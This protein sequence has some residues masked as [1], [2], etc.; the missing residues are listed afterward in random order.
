MPIMRDVAREAGTSISTVSNV[1]NR[2]RRVSPDTELRVRLAMKK[3]GYRPNAY[4][5][6]LRRKRSR[7]LGLVIPDITNPFFAELV[8][9]AERYAREHGYSSL[10]CNTD[11]A[12][13][14]ERNAVEMLESRRADG[15]LIAPTPGAEEILEE[16]ATRGVGCVLLDRFPEP[17]PFPAVGSQNLEGARAATEHLIELGHN[18]IAIIVGSSQLSTSRERLQ[19]YR[20]AIEANCLSLDERLIVTADD[21]E[22][23]VES[24][25]H[26]FREISRPT[27]AFATNAPRTIGTLIALR[28]SGLRC[29]DDVSVV[30]FDDVDWYKAFEPPLT[31]VAQD[32]FTI[33]YRATRRLIALLEGAEGA[34]ARD[35]ERIPVRFTCRQSTRSPHPNAIR[36]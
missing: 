34:N 7:C 16:L 33:G 18:R 25:F 1:V 15:L 22:E 4:A 14:I 2:R 24:V 31:V 26:L 20:D 36:R 8:R 35:V 21:L 28:R 27:A 29:P 32:S 23:T 3:L 13:D 6:S 30:G 12:S 11:E 9:G 19:G 17:S 10:I 5:Q